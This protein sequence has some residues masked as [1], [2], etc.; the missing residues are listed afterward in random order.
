[1]SALQVGGAVR[2]G[3]P[4]VERPADR[5]LPEALLRGELC[6]VLAPRQIGKSSLRVRAAATLR[7]AGL[8]VV[9]IDLSGFGAA[10]LDPESWFYGLA[11]ELGAG[12]DRADAHRV[13]EETGGRPP[14]ARWLTTL[15]RLVVRDP[16]PPVVVLLDE[17]D[18][19]LALPF[20]G[21]DLFA[22]IRAAHDARAEDP[23]WGRLRFGLLGVASPADL[24]QDPRRTPF[25]V[26]RAVRL[27][28]F[29][30]DEAAALLPAL[31]G[32][33]A[34]PQA[35]LDA[36]LGWTS[37]HPFQTAQ[38]CTALVEDPA[39][40]PAE[41]PEA[42]AR[43]GV[44]RLYRGPWPD[45]GLE[46]AGRLL[47]DAATPELLSLY[48]RALAP[49]G[50]P[51]DPRSPAQA[52]LSLT[53]LVAV[54][55]ASLQVRNEIIRSTY[56][57]E[58]VSAL[59]GRRQ[60]RERAWAWAEAGRPD[61]LLLDERALGGLRAEGATSGELDREEEAYLLRSE[62]HIVARAA[63]VR[64]RGL[65]AVALTLLLLL[66]AA[67]LLAWE[68]RQDAAMQAMAQQVADIP[69]RAAIPGR[70]EEALAE[71]LEAWA[72]LRETPFAALATRGLAETLEV[73]RGPRLGEGGALSLAWLDAH[74]L[75]VG[76]S[77][78]RLEK[79]VNFHMV[80]AQVA[81]GSAIS[82][83]AVSSDGA[84]AL[85]GREDGEVRWWDLRA[86][87]PVGKPA[88][89]HA[90]APSQTC[91]QRGAKER[92][93]GVRVARLSPGGLGLTLGAEGGVR[94]W[95]PGGE[96]RALAVQGALDAVFSPQGD[97]VAV[98]TRGGELQIFDATS[99]DRLETR[100]PWAGSPADP[101][102][103]EGLR[104]SP[105]AL[106]AL[107]S[108][109]SGVLA[110]A[111]RHGVVTLG[112]WEPG[113]PTLEL[114]VPGLAAWS[115]TL[116][117]DGTILATSAED[118]A[119]RLWDTQTGALRM[120]HR[121]PRQGTIALEFSPDGAWLAAT[122][123][124]DRVFV[125]DVAGGDLLWKAASMDG[126]GLALAFSPD[127][128][129][130][131]AA[132]EAGAWRFGA[133]P[134]V[135]LD[136]WASP[137][138]GRPS[139]LSVAPDGAV[140][141]TWTD[142]APEILLPGGR[143]SAEQP[144]PEGPV[145]T[146]LFSPDGARLLWSGPSG[147]WL[148]RR[149]EAPGPQLPGRAMYWQDPW[150]ADGSRVALWD[151]GTI[152]ILD[153]DGA[154][155]STLGGSLRPELALSPDGA[156]A[157]AVQG[158]GTLQLFDAQSGALLGKPCA[159]GSEILYS[160]TWAREGRRFA[161]GGSDRVC[162]GA[163]GEARARQVA[164]PGDGR[165]VV[166]AGGL[167]WALDNGDRLLGVDE[168]GAIRFEAAGHPGRARL[169]RASRD[170]ERM[171]SGAE[172]GDVILWSGRG[173]QLARWQIHRGVARHVAFSADGASIYSAGDDG[174]IVRLPGSAEAL[175]DLGCDW[176]GS[177]TQR[178]AL[179]SQRDRR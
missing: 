106:V 45:P 48:R 44:D 70:Q 112:G 72:A 161:A 175:A 71:A 115:I 160:F 169:L 148:A 114:P 162:L 99:G 29:R 28:D 157:L 52:R 14:A 50:L 73:V 116:S 30:P 178:P 58:W 21:E 107:A 98:A 26:G 4:Y 11:M 13:W 24:I 85:V 47:R 67:A 146:A 123:H 95:E 110:A 82:A 90:P 145:D 61:A 105:D 38:L 156:R 41:T 134:S 83:L 127:S 117:P 60:L 111:G 149:G 142:G 159:L 179:C 57:Q 54:R 101:L 109:R 125:W 66:A 100:G 22:A 80:A 166:W 122:G 17:I 75:L 81:L 65:I 102:E 34:P 23:A 27:E 35:L 118:G 129:H 56:N 147:A 133:G 120:E 76:R 108:S 143:R 79:L 36:V 62:A 144:L 136:R 59:Q 174:L 172:D 91:L 43:R 164:L 89:P 18:A 10:G 2:A 55:G 78:G 42:R 40:D 53:G 140:A 84:R 177:E 103:C 16:E 69:Q 128:L 1:M 126:T 49:A 87:A 6:Y 15:E 167:L 139:S 171:V 135:A 119:I 165:H 170:G 93:P 86:W 130:L 158:E 63:R 141:V 124:D 94:L 68:E 20:G 31:T 96:G 5:L 46:A 92:S 137:E 9:S 8:R 74:S 51:W 37:G 12:L 150:S 155:I 19:V 173:E 113:A 64:A 121:E 3:A 176:I 104:E 33:G 131:A 152:R 138:K 7:A 153:R 88:R 97:R 77:D 151:A 39:P 132:G 168:A 32:L 25:N 154:T 163:L